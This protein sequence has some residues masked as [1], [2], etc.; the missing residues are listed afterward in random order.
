MLVKSTLHTKLELFRIHHV[1][2]QIDFS[3]YKHGSRMNQLFLF[4]TDSL[5]GSLV[6]NSTLWTFST[7]LGPKL[8]SSLSREKHQCPRSFAID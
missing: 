6:A 5:T 1:R 4:G 3:F 2:N 7:N 8:L